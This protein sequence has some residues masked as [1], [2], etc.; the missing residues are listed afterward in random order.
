MS[1]SLQLTYND[2]HDL[3]V[4]CDNAIRWVEHCK[5]EYDGYEP[6]EDEYVDEELSM[7]DNQIRCYQKLKAGL[8]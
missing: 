8:K 2:L 3:S 7:M 1:N 5:E 6:G 4:A